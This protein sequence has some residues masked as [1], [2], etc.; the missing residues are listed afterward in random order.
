MW[1]TCKHGGFKSILEHVSRREGGEWNIGEPMKDQSVPG[2][3]MKDQSVSGEPMK[4]QSV[5]GE[6]MKEKSVSGEPMKD[7]SVAGE[8][9]KEQLVAGERFLHLGADVRCL[10]ICLESR[11][12]F[13]RNCFQR[14]HT[15]GL[16]S[17]NFCSLVLLGKS[18]ERECGAR[19][20]R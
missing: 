9:M 19:E 8:P 6:P 11:G 20:S 13:S 12:C 1:S 7:Q 4:E 16:K 15:Q 3:P 10:V 17:A 5:S 2:E 18:Y 14:R